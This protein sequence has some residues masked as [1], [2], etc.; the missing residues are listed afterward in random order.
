MATTNQRGSTGRG[1][2]TSAFGVSK[3][4][5]HDATAF[6]DRFPAPVLSDDAT[7]AGSDGITE[8]CRLGDARHMD[9]LPD[10]SVA[11]VV[12]S[13]PYFAGKTYEAELGVD[14]VPASYVDYLAM[15]RDVF[16]E[17]V[18]VLEPGGRIAVNVANL[19]RK[20]FR[21]LAADVTTILQDDLGM[22]LRGEVIW[23]KAKGAGGNCAWGSYRSPANPALRDVTERVIIASKG[24]FDR[25]L[26]ATERASR[27]L[28]HRATI[29]GD[30]FLAATLDLW[31]IDAESATKIGH[32][33]PFPVELPERLIEL[34][35]FAGD[36][37]CD[38]FCGSG[39][40]LV[41]AKKTGRRGVGYDLD[42]AY[43]AL[44]AERIAA[45][46]AGHR[47]MPERTT[48]AEV[49][50]RFT[51]AGVT[52][53]PR[54]DRFPGCP[55]TADLSVVLSDD[56]TIQVLIAGDFSMGRTGAMTTAGCLEVLGK[57]SLLQGAGAESIC[58]VVPQAPRPQS[59]QAKILDAASI[60]VIAASV[61]S[62][63]HYLSR[64]STP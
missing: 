16:A 4:E 35:T 8:G 2:A 49:T 45:T 59:E 19:G 60:D 58:I 57:A 30:E 46:E 13:P 27:G 17:C 63:Q 50:E 31:S 61:A 24:R 12:T 23:Q 10:A 56:T 7:V 53:A 34:Y 32:P 1:T 33:A 28:P 3:R 9:G 21:N 14:G 22:L 42:P 18:R 38:P 15:L 39:S 47:E 51:N 55:L 64:R 26:N 40:T 36:L 6:Y 52:V 20:P 43:V 5:S 54:P 48:K 44:S 25:A 37:I 41:A 11:L 29:G 62:I